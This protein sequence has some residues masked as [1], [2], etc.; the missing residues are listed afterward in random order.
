MIQPGTRSPG[1]AEKGPVR[2]GTDTDS[3]SW[4]D[5]TDLEKRSG[6]DINPGRTST[7]TSD[8]ETAE[9]DR[10]PA[11]RQRTRDGP[12]DGAD[13]AHTGV[14]SRAVSRVLTKVSTKSSWNPGPPPDGGLQAW[15]A[16]KPPF[17]PF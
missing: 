7:D 13:G 12:S 10:N 5:G 3:P 15:T 4:S 9:E 17:C 1:D 14:L 8:A 2:S 6:E 11:S 16:G